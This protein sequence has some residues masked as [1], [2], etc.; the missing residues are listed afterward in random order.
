M[1]KKHL[2]FYILDDKYT[3]LA[4]RAIRDTILSLLNLFLFYN[5]ITIKE[6][7]SFQFKI[8][9]NYVVKFYISNISLIVFFLKLLKLY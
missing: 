8:L 7:H 5:F 6:A 1:V 2:T 4:K 3:M 9:L